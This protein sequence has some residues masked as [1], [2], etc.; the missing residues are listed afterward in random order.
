MHSWHL[1]VLKCCILCALDKA[2]LKPVLTLDQ[3]TCHSISFLNQSYLSVLLLTLSFCF[4]SLP[5][6][7]RMVNEEMT[8]LF[9][10]TPRLVSTFLS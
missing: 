3:N 2:C 4:R 5:M 6:N 8:E 9:M 7:Y 10:R 1:L